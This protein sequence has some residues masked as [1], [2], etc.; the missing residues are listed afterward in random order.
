[1]GVRVR[2]IH[3]CAGVDDG[4]CGERWARMNSQEVIN[5]F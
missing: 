2:V 4:G 1:M 3:L 5:D